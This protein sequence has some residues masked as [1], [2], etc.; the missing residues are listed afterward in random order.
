VRWNAFVKN[1][2]PHFPIDGVSYEAFDPEQGRP[3]ERVFVAG[4]SRE[5]SSGLV[6]VARKDG[7]R[8]ARAVL[9]YLA[10]LPKVKD[11][12]QVRQNFNAHLGQLDKYIVRKGDLLK[13][14]QAECQ[15]AQERGLVEF[16]Y[17]SNEEML[18]AIRREVASV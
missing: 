18:E 8:G 14:E 11:M 12:Q 9:A 5:A 17:D 4:W 2:E 7:E 6:G 10:S 3:I 1:P 13:L 16:K 15:E